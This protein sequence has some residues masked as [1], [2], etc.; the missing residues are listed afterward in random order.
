MFEKALKSHLRFKTTKGLI[1]TED[2]FDLDLI[3]KNGEADLDSLA[4]ALNKEVK[5]AGEESFVKTKTKVNA[6]AEL[7]FEIVKHVIKIKLEEA[8]AKKLLL[9]KKANSQKIM[10]LISQKKDEALS[11][12]SLEELEKLLAES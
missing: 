5:E 8:D 7:K 9:E 10:A 3:S 4:K 2:L 6:L 1:T 12:K 11:S